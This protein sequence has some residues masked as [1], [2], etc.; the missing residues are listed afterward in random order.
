[1]IFSETDSDRVGNRR[2]DLGIAM[3]DAEFEQVSVR[4][5]FD[6]DGTDEFLARPVTF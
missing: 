2:R 6:F 1:V 4:N 3:E 5:V